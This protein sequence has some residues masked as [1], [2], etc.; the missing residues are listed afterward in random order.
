MGK[1][2]EDYFSELQTDLVSICLEYVDNRA[3][4]IYIY[5]S[6]EP[7]MYYVN[8]FYNIEGNFVLKHELNDINL[9]D[10]NYVYDTST[11][12][13]ISLQRIGVE[14]LEKIN[15]NCKEYNREMPTEIKLHY[16]IKN[17]KL[18]GKYKYDLIYSNDDTLLP[19]S[20]FKSWFEEVRE[21]KY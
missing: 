21:Y 9:I 17:N 12:R 13:Q 16:D 14:I 4:D 10:Q 19:N 18:K 2:F 1:V 7:E 3:N 15:T 5:C 20:I 8:V 11:E 6:Y